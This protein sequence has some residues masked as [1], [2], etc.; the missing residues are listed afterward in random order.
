M[1]VGII[2][3]PY[4]A[5]DL[6]VNISAIELDDIPDSRNMIPCS[7]CIAFAV[8]DNVYRNIFHSASRAN[9]PMTLLLMMRSLNFHCSMQ[10]AR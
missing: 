3:C 5:L 2:I 10:L 7:V 4:N 1:I 9:A 6:N 8:T